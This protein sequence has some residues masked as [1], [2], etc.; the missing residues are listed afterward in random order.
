M[1][2]ARRVCFFAVIAACAD[3]QRVDFECQP[4]GPVP[5]LAG[6]A[7]CDGLVANS[8]PAGQV[9]V[10]NAPNCQMPAGGSRYALLVSKEPAAASVPVGTVLPRPFAPALTELRI[11]LGGALLVQFQYSFHQYAW[12]FIPPTNPAAVNDGFDISVVDAGG[13][14]LKL[15]ARG[16]AVVA[17][18]PI[19][20]CPPV[21]FGFGVFDQPLP[22]GS[23]LSFVAYNA[24]AAATDSQLLVDSVQITRIGFDF[25]CQ[26]GGSSFAPSWDCQGVAGRTGRAEARPR[27]RPRN[28]ECPPKARSTPVSR[29]AA[30]SRA[31]RRVP[32]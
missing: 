22:P 31:S 27:P 12:G 23:Y 6:P 14:R 10:V 3:A 30:T 21:E 20:T 26:P 1:T 7:D 5:P 2:S 16:D 17:A 13:N 25:E 18:S 15:L 29:P 32:R 24:G 8:N 9:T 19:A 28:A 4:L 11:G